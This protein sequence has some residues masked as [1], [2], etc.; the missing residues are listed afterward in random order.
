M[1]SSF[2]DTSYSDIYNNI[3]NFGNGFSP[4]MLYLWVTFLL[5][6]EES[7][8]VTC[9]IFFFLWPHTKLLSGKCTL[10]IIIEEQLGLF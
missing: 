5:K 8:E 7:A 6:E 1:Q 4:C 9:I 3:T 10:G 2:M